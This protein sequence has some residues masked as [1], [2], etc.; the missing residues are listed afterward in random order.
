MNKIT[1]LFDL[2]NKAKTDDRYRRLAVMVYEDYCAT[3]G[4]FDKAK[5]WFDEWADENYQW[6]TT[7]GF[8]SCQRMVGHI[9]S[10]IY[11]I[12]NGEMLMCER[13]DDDED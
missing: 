11:R 12:E 10:F 1:S 5:R 2:F 3:R 13:P 9:N 7:K 8:C 6:P 4:D